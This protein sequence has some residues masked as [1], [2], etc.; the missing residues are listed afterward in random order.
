[1]AFV[2]F[3]VAF[4]DVAAL[5]RKLTETILLIIFIASLICVAVWGIKSFLPLSFAVF[6]SFLELTYVNAAIFP[7]VLAHSIG[8]ALVVGACEDIAICKDVRA[9]TVL[10]TVAPLT[11]VSITVLPLMNS[12]AVCFALFPFANIRVSKNAFPNSLAFF[13]AMSPLAF[14]NLPISP[15]VN[16][17]AMGLVV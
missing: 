1:V 13:K 16:T 14:V 2:F 8:L 12:V 15:A 5:P 9:L 17:L 3:V 6:L 10:E 11:L 4:V 7:L